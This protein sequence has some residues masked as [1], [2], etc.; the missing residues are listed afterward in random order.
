MILGLDRHPVAACFAELDDTVTALRP[1]GAPPVCLNAH[2]FQNDVP[3]G[4][5]VYN[6]ENVGVQV[7]RW[8]NF[9]GAEIWDFSKRNVERWGYVD[10]KHV[11]VGYHPSMERFTMLPWEQ[12]DIDVVLTGCLNDRRVRILVALAESGLHVEHIG[13]GQAYG[14]ARD[15]VLARSKLA[16]NVLY[17]PDGVHPVLRSAHCAANRLPVVCEAAPETPEW[18]SASCRYEDVI[19]SVL[20]LLKKGRHASAHFAAR[21]YEAFRDHPMVLP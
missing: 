20:T 15:A 1:A 4:A 3:D 7:D 6:L 13:P 8:E 18:V 21:S 16:L 19:D 2:T 11:P 9:G 10:V 14:A 5:V 17:H 12:R